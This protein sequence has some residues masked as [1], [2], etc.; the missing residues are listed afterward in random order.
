M[1]MSGGSGGGGPSWSVQI[2][3]SFRFT[4][5]FGRTLTWVTHR[6]CDLHASPGL[7]P[8]VASS[9]RNDSNCDAGLRSL[10][11]VVPSEAGRVFKT[12]LDMVPYLLPGLFA[13]LFSY[14]QLTQRLLPCNEAVSRSCQPQ[15]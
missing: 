11:L 3:T 2:C 7:V 14:F 10:K 8:A 6:L 12:R 5:K 1:M 15:K 4:R 9:V 13:H